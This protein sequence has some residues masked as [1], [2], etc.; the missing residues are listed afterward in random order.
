MKLSFFR[1]LFFRTRFLLL[2]LSFS[3]LTG[4][5]DKWA[6]L[7]PKGPVGSSIRL[8]LFTT[9]GLML[10]VVIPTLV[11]IVF[12]ARKYR[13]SNRDAEYSPEW[14]HSSKIEF[15]AWGVPILIIGVLATITYITSHTLDPRQ[16]LDERPPLKIQV[17][18][19]DWKWLFLYPEENIA[20]VNEVA[21]PINQPVEFLITSDSTMNS[22]FIPQLGSQLYAMSGM[23]N[24][25]NLMATEPGDYAGISSNYSGY[26]F[27]EM[28]FNARAMSETDYQTWL[29]KVHA[30]GQTLDMPLYHQLA[31]KSRANPVT[32]YSPIDPLVFK[33]VI[34]SY[35]GVQTP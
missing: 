26:G 15:F 8:T 1:M 28:K 22:F 12:F 6:L 10:I 23:E 25:L 21:F 2:S 29:A 17:I 20:V 35:T 27:A 24:R 4:C 5:S 31:Q 19:L 7:V 9:V 14:E 33:N 30:S 18:A 13:A 3:L 32:Y 11:M 34:E 16:R